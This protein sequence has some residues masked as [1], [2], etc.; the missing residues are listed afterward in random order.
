MLLVLVE[1]FCSA[2]EIAKE[3]Q[4][5]IFDCG[6]NQFRAGAWLTAPSFVIKQLLVCHVYG[7]GGSI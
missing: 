4:P 5:G 7:I 2:A 1:I 6:F 3:Q